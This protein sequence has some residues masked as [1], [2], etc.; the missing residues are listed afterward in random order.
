MAKPILIFA[1]I[2]ALWPAAASAQARLNGD[3]LAY[4]ML[5]PECIFPDLQHN[6]EFRVC[7]R[8]FVDDPVAVVKRATQGG[9]DTGL[10]IKV[11]D[12]HGEPYSE[13]E[14]YPAAL[15]LDSA[16]LV[17]TPFFRFRAS[18]PFPPDHESGNG[19][20]SLSIGVHAYGRDPAGRSVARI[21]WPVVRVPYFDGWGGLRSLLDRAADEDD[22]WQEGWQRNVDYLNSLFASWAAIYG[23][24]SVEECIA[25][26]PWYDGQ[27]GSLSN[28]QVARIARVTKLRVV[29]E[30]CNIGLSAQTPSDVVVLTMREDGRIGGRCERRPEPLAECW[31][32]D[33]DRPDSRLCIGQPETE[34]EGYRP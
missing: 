28:E 23:C 16:W 12:F 22:P 9:G 34:P 21:N 7:A 25:A 27:W 8:H 10:S 4:R 2:A 14:P 32:P 18:S 24:A 30:A 13:Q 5:H 20:H 3:Q 17:V 15:L 31:K 33:H 19:S 29:N 6:P 26:Y 1:A 11:Q